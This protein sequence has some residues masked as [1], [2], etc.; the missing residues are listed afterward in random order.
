MVEWRRHAIYFAPEAG[1]ML[2]RFGAAWLGWDADAGVEP[3]AVLLPDLP[4]P[5][6]ELVAAPRRYGF[7]ATLKPPFRLAEGCAEAALDG[8]AAAVAADFPPFALRLRLAWLGG[9]LALV[10]EQEPPALAALAEACV[11]RLDRFR[12]PPE[13]DEV[14]QRRAAGLDAVEAAHLMRWGYPYVLERFRFHLTLTGPVAVEHRAAV[15]AGLGK[16]LT[17]VLDAP[18]PVA[19]LCHFGEGGDGRFRVISRHRLG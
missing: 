4:L 2:A 9:F 14:A 5:R 12:A 8:A 1:S 7:H 13:A 18:V 15:H 11:T 6:S 17:P 10:P 19:D 16:Q 3:A